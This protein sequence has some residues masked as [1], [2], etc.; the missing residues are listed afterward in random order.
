MKN[1]WITTWAGSKIHYV[2]DEIHNEN[3]P[4]IIGCKG[5]KE[6]KQYDYWHRLDG[7]AIEYASGKQSWYLLGQRINVN[8]QKEFEKWLKLRIFL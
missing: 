7:P 3:E 1:G 4:A 5:T 2:N 6:W 8:S